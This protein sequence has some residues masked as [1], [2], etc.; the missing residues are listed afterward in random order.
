[1]KIKESQRS[2]KLEVLRELVLKLIPQIEKFDIF[3]QFLIEGI[4]RMTTV[5]YMDSVFFA[6]KN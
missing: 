2:K 3:N 6:V 5:L 4:A 1:M